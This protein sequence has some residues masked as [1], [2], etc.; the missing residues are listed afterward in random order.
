M[1]PPAQTDTGEIRLSGERSAKHHGVHLSG[2]PV[3]LTEC[4]FS[5]LLTLL[6]ACGEPGSGY[7]SLNPVTVCRLRATLD[8]AA[9]P[10]TGISLIQTG[11]GAEYRLALPRER[12]ASW[13]LVEES[14]Y[15]LVGLKTVSEEEAEAIR[16]LGTPVQ[17]A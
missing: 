3:F 11:N 1:R 6:V 16:R 12:P 13:L 2:Q 15:E 8:D 14:F 7:V 9:G 5:A 10:G 4:E 17:S